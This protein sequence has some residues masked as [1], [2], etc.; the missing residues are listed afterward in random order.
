MFQGEKSPRRHFV[1]TSISFLDVAEKHP[2]LL[3]CP[4]QPVQDPDFQRLLHPWE[5]ASWKTPAS[6]LAGVGCLA[7]W[8]TQLQ[9]HGQLVI[10]LDSHIRVPPP[11]SHPRGPQFA[12]FLVFRGLRFSFV[13]FTTVVVIK[14]VLLMWHASYVQLFVALHLFPVPPRSRATG[15]GI[16]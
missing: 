12:H 13:F 9:T 7:E 11:F 1:L 5:E 4:H 6:P 2:S 15:N 14:S 10:E 16:E 3:S 8:L